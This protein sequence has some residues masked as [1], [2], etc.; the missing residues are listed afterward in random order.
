MQKLRL[1]VDLKKSLE[2]FWKGNA[3]QEDLESTAKSLRE[4]HWRLQDDLGIEQIPSNDFSYYDHVLDTITML[5][6][7]PKRYNW[8]G[9][10][11]TLDTFL[12]TTTVDSSHETDL[13]IVNGVEQT[14]SSFTKIKRFL[15]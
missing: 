9:N 4:R 11:V 10:A 5:G 7:I 15:C 2:A 3:S 14:D 12:T 1:S 13:F 8:D 6:A